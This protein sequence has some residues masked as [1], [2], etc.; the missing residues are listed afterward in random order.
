MTDDWI[1]S[2]LGKHVRIYSGV[3]PSDVVRKKHGI[4]PYVKVEDLNNCAKYQS[5]SRE[6]TDTKKGF[7]PAGSIIF[8]KRGAAIM[9]NKIRIAKVDLAMDTNL[10]AVM[11][12]QGL[13]TE[14]F[15][16]LVQREGL[17][18][19]ADTSTIPQLNN[20]HILPYA[21][22]LP[23]LHEQVKI[24]KILSIWDE[25]IETLK[26]LS[27]G[28][29][30]EFLSLQR[31]LLG[32]EGE[33]RDDWEFVPLRDVATRVRRKTDGDNHPVMTIASKSGFILQSDKY[34]R[35]MAGTSLKSYTL[36]R[37][38]EFAY[39]KGNS[40]TF[41]QGCIFEL[42]QPAALV[43]H[44][45]FCF[46]LNEDLHRDFY[47]HVFAAGLLNRQLSQRINS[48]VRNDGLLNINADDF[49]DCKIPLPPFCEQKKIANVLNVAE[50]ELGLLEQKLN[51]LKQQKRGLMQ[52]LLSGQWRVEGAV[53]R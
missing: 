8:P 52:K 22:T 51:V 47:T 6:Y 12:T 36:L 5:R 20:K 7:A 3:S 34:S 17:S 10:M 35:E 19:L 43:P 46:A 44:V 2:N 37:E 29:G 50:R 28:K 40:L 4:Y 48:G 45:Y 33:S 11:P 13:D 53:T 31:S 27:A 32:V 14:F 16:Y 39:N 15:F 38:H 18:K 1:T 24:A 41:P 42:N 49:F 9:N 25:A 23:P 21:V 26:R 30:K